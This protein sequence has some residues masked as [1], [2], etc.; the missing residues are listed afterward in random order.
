MTK[1][2]VVAALDYLCQTFVRS[3]SKRSADY[4]KLCICWKIYRKLRLQLS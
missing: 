4:Q 2:F 3:D 1:M